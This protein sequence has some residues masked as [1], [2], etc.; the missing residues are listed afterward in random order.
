MARN[1]GKWWSDT[2]GIGAQRNVANARVLFQ[3]NIKG[4]SSNEPRLCT[5]WEGPLPHELDPIALEALGGETNLD[6]AI[7]ERRAAH[8]EV[9][10]ESQTVRNFSINVDP[11]S[12]HA[13]QVFE[14]DLGTMELIC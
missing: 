6:G 3:P 13:T 4:T 10:P 1:K 7:D 12:S 5:L 2:F 8:C 11:P 9:D 14:H